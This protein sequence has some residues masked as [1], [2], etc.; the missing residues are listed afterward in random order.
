V[1]PHWRHVLS[2]P[3]DPPARAALAWRVF[4]G[5]GLRAPEA[6]ALRS[7]G[8][9]A[10]FPARQE[11]AVGVLSGTSVRGRRG[12]YLGRAATGCRGS[13]PA[14]DRRFGSFAGSERRRVGVL[15][16]ALAWALGLAALW[17]SRRFPRAFGASSAA[18]D[19]RS[20]GLAPCGSALGLGRFFCLRQ[21]PKVPHQRRRLFLGVRIVTGAFL[22]AAFLCL[23]F[24]G[25]AAG[26]LGFCS[27]AV[28]VVVS[29]PL[30]ERPLSPA[31]VAVRFIPHR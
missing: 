20:F 28:G 15:P 19:G 31:T 22:P 26:A 10:E 25:S 29:S 9:P 27:C 24:A 11:F 14:S 2:P 12:L 23:G 7:W 21:H 4:F 5:L 30:Q 3:K 1:F 6:A 8:A 16:W 18:Y 17:R 13:V